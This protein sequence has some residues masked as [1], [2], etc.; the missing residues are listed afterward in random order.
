MSSASAPVESY[1]SSGLAARALRQIA[2]SAR[3]RP[4]SRWRPYIAAGP[5]FELI[6]LSDAPLKKPAGYYTIG[7]KNIGLFKAAF[8]FGNTAPLDGGGIFQFGVQYGGG[9]KYR[10]TPHIITRADFR[11]TWSPN[12]NIIQDSYKDFVFDF[13]DDTYTTS[14]SVYKPEQRFFQDRFTLGVAFAF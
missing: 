10:V 5:T 3:D 11:E 2:S 1:R 8:D 7:L 9:I 13:G 14:T 12:P 4:E 6:A